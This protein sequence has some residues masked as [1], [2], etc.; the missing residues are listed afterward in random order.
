MSAAAGDE[1]LALLLLDLST[2]DETAPADR[3]LGSCRD[4][5]LH[6]GAPLA[7]EAASSRETIGGD[8]RQ[9]FRDRSAG[10]RPVELHRTSLR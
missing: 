1:G 6:P 5:L 2:D 8:E 7:A 9:P 4:Q 3:G 10:V